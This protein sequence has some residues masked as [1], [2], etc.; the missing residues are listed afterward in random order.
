MRKDLPDTKCLEDF[1]PPVVSRVFDKDGNLVGEFFIQKRL[2]VDLR[3]IPEEMIYAT[4]AIEDRKFYRH[5]GVDIVGIVRAALQNI[6]ARK[7]VQ[8]A[9][10]I[11]Q[12]LARNLFLTQERTVVR[13]MKE[14]LLAIQIERRHSKDE[15]LTMYFN[16]IYY[17]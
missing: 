17:G 2:P 7:T 15:I 4:I 16:Q 1:S 10:T 11:T 6:K 5:W 8:G 14:I 13:K 3:E 12:Q 9:S